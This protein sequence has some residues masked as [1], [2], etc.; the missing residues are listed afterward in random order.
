MDGSQKVNRQLVQDF[1]TQY[2]DNTSVPPFTSTP[3]VQR[4]DGA[5]HATASA[6]ENVCWLMNRI[7]QLD[8]DIKTIKQDVIKQMEC[9]LT[10]LKASL[11]AMIEKSSS[12]KTYADA[13]GSPKPV[14]RTE[15]QSTEN[16]QNI[17]DSCFIDEGY[18]DQSGI[19]AKRSSSET[20]L[21]TVYV[22]DDRENTQQ[23]IHIL[24]P[25]APS[26]TQQRDQA[27][28]IQHHGPA[29]HTQRH[30]PAN[31]AQ[32]H[33]PAIRTQR[34]GPAIRT[35][36]NVPT[37]RTQLPVE[38]PQPV[39]VRVTNR[40]QSFSRS[41]PNTSRNFS[42]FA[43]TTR[44]KTLIVGDSIMKGI[45][46]RG[47]Q[48]DVKICTR[49]GAT[50]GDLWEEISI[51]DLKSF[52]RIIIC[53]G[54]NDCSSRRDTTEF[55]E[56]YDQLIGFIKSV[57]KDCLV[58]V[59]KIVPRGDVDVSSYNSSI[60]RIVD[61]WAMHN[62]YCIG[63]SHELFFGKDR[64]PLSRYYYKDG[65]HL[66]HSGTKR[67]LDAWNR[68][69]PIVQDYTQC[70]YKASRSPRVMNRQRPTNNPGR[71][72]DYNTGRYRNNGQRGNGNR[73]CYGCHMQG[74]ILAECW[75]SQ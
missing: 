65:V 58:Y 28:A 7:Q 33:R 1:Q 71:H 17:E 36:H 10:E 24:T 29:I 12:Q 63:D 48:K 38:N 13:I 61:H 14:S 45:N 20:R 41:L 11:I 44:D 39:T 70:V 18:G 67:L 6:S 64:M 40:N 75:N 35:Q 3:N 8:N 73:R 50:I 27:M 54:G 43:P 22:A 2:L 74:H 66:S 31:I 46:Y 42:G 4:L 5:N 47:L 34:H 9:K 55:E 59:S 25:I 69:V 19:D 56:K 15:N 32:R 68:H 57:N 53:I 72:D 23:Q 52:A 62:V 49:S 26:E 16:S 30:G 60:L 37:T 21:K 51:Y